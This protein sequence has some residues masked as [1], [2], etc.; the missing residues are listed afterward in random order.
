MKKNLKRV[1]LLAVALVAMGGGS[2]LSAKGWEAVK[3]EKITGQHV[4]SE[5]DIEI[6]AGGGIIYV[7]T[8]KHLNIKIFTILGSRIADDN[9]A[10]GSYQF[11]VPAHGVY[12]V[13]TGD[14]TC[15][16]AV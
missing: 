5:T 10:P 7:N 2:A 13:K 12:I 14:L 16:V 11:V 8:T 6:K 9:L 1:L 4:V 15:K 3:T